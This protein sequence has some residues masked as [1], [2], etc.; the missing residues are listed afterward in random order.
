MSQMELPDQAS[1]SPAAGIPWWNPGAADAIGAIVERGSFGVAVIDADL[2][3]L[4]VSPGLAALYGLDT[5]RA[6]GKR[7]DEVLPAPHDDH[8]DRHLRQILASGT[9]MTRAETWGTPAAP[10]TRRSF[11]SSFSR[12][13]D[14]SGVP[15]G[16]VVLVSE[17][18]ELRSAVPQGASAAEAQLQLLTRITEA[19]S[20]HLDVAGVTEV[21]MTGALRAMEAS[22]AALMVFDSEAGKLIPVASSGLSDAVLAHLLEPSDLGALLP[23]CDAAR[24]QMITTWG[25]R[26]ELDA[27]Y[28][29]LATYSSDH[30]A[31]AF[32]P[33]RTKDVVG[34]VLAF[35]WRL[36]RSFGDTDV[37]LL[38]SVGRQ[39]A[40]ALEH[41]RILDA[42]REA[43]RAMEFLV[44]V[45][46]FVVESSDEGVY[47]MSNGNR[48]LTFNNRFCEMMGLPENA[49]EVGDDSAFL[50]EHCKSL[51]AH[52]DAVTRHLAIGR[53]RPFD[54]LAA[55]FE[56]RDGRVMAYRSSPIVDRRN[57]ALGRVWYLRDETRHRVQ[58]T[59]Q[60]AAMEQ[61]QAH[62]EHQAFLLEAA[63]II[64]QADGYAE[65]LERLA[66]VAVPTLAD[67]CLVDTLT[68]DGRI[69]RM[70]AKHSDP[71]LQPLVDEL[72]SKYAPDPAGEHP[73]IEV[74]HTGR[75]RWS[76]TMSDDFLRQTTRD[77]HHFEL[78]KR[79]NFTSYMALSAYRRQSHPGFDHPGLRWIGTAVRFCRLGTGGGLHFV[80][81]PGCGTGAKE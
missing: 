1:A 77:D 74:M 13:D 20:E 45:T 43:R 7:V 44:E 26:A 16:V 55:D 79:L 65:T 32:V 61:L 29:A 14:P 60:R 21:A 42:E 15:L 28:P 23:H 24:S 48:I 49:I 35:A 62:H 19:L 27:E 52:P 78:L 46:K 70:A 10:D 51:A 47:A 76:T 59:V 39:C 56:L 36:D 4:F 9:P 81:R 66:A 64:A 80:C 3:F 30:Q 54:H 18:T 63:E 31:W 53:Q 12:L 5:S 8:F 58:D 11:S 40:L 72:G 57:I 73:S 37:A 38:D 50:L 2:T 34:G 71:A 17:T 22:A 6:V 41:A 25:S 75:V 69:V 33:M 67:L 68:W